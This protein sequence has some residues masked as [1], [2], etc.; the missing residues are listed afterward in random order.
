MSP[1]HGREV[2][3]ALTLP[4]LAALIIA[5][6]AAG[7]AVAGV[8]DWVQSH[9]SAATPAAT[10][11][12]GA[13]LLYSDTQVSVSRDGTVKRVVRCVYRA[14]TQKFASNAQVQAVTNPRIRLLGLRAWAISPNGQTDGVGESDAVESA[15]P[16][17]NGALFNEW[18]MK[19]LREPK[20]VPNGVFAAEVATEER[21]IGLI[22]EWEPRAT[23]PVVEAHYELELP[24]DWQ[25][26]ANW[27][28]RPEE[29]VVMKAANIWSWTL[30]D[31]KPVRIESL[32]PPWQATAGQLM[33]SM[34][35]SQGHEAGFQTW[36]EMGAWYTT[37][38]H[39]RQEVTKEM[40]QKVADLTDKESAALEKVQTLAE[41]VQQGVRYVAIEIGIGDYMPHSAAEVFSNQYGD[42][43]DKATLLASMLKTIGIDSHYVIVNTQR[44]AV[45]AN[46]PA[47][48][49]FN[50]MILAIS[51]PTGNDAS[52]LLAMVDNPA[53]G[54]LLIFDPTDSL[55][56]FGRLRGALQGGY[57]LLVTPSGGELVQLPQLPASTNSIQRTGTMTLD[58]T[59]T[60]TGE[61]HEEWTGDQ[62]SAERARLRNL[63]ESTEQERILKDRLAQFFTSFDLLNASLGAVRDT[64]GP[65]MWRYS[66]EAQNYAKSADN[67]LIV[68]PR[69]LATEASLFL[70]TDEPRESP[71][72]FAAPMRNS[73]E[74]DIAVPAGYRAEDLPD[75]VNLESDFV[76]YHSRTQLAGQT[77]RYS[78]SF[79]IKRLSVP[80]DKVEELRKF[81]RAIRNDE[82][83]QVVLVRT[84][85]ATA[86]Q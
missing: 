83:R 30:R 62:A 29:P 70:E 14:L 19:I 61:V 5:C 54:R 12:Q 47:H 45:G 60:L 82:N 78:R 16:V 53:L 50:H 33:V 3:R 68:R 66:I 8:P 21:N 35:P 25:A 48:F 49:A 2:N 72:E 22:D 17:A 40:A 43:K 44:G 71:V 20:V 80:V 64:S 34:I 57:G 46:S 67:L 24:K 79:E 28:G 18:R 86:R 39:G 38:S 9:A 77:I 85:S 51:V 42:C 11:D 13:V 26:K 58:P 41:Y 63:Y 27:I 4:A 56:P 23:I 37:L 81:Y 75:P 74:F 59:G 1:R 65:L 52:N 32:M 69:I 31:Q 15:L 76:A 7:D 10:A 55:T 84:S 36:N 6:T 73:D